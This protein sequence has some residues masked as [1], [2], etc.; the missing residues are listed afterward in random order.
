MS[1]PD[2]QD[3]IDDRKFISFKD[4]PNR[5]AELLFLDNGIFGTNSFGNPCVL[6]QVTENNK[7]MT[8]SASRN[9]A[10]TLKEHLPVIGKMFRIT[11]QGQGYETTYEVTLL[12]TTQL[13]KIIKSETT[14][15][16]PTMN[17]PYGCVLNDKLMEFT[18]PELLEHLKAHPTK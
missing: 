3:R 17:C 12:T 1:E 14:A 9:L 2:W 8:L 10:R 11:Q 6:F 13:Q 15:K 16:E 18:N 7:E 4:R 5:T